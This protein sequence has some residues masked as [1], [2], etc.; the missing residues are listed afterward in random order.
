MPTLL[1]IQTS[2]RGDQS[3][4]RALGELFTH[5]WRDAHPGGVV[6]ER[7]L[8]A[9]PVP[10]MDVDWIAGVY[11]PSAV[12]RTPA[13]RKALAASD[14]LIDELQRADHVLVCTPMYNFTIPAA[15]KS[16]IDYVVRPNLT[17]ALAPGWP[18][19]LGDKSTRVLITARDTYPHGSDDDQ[20]TP[21]LRR[22][23][24]FMGVRDLRSLLVGGSSGVNRGEVRLDDH[25]ARFAEPVARMAREVGAGRE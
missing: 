2:P 24:A 17:F 1:R 10:T 19:L 18:G 25:I 5:H 21:V 13:M 22:A 8:A 14:E 7:D 12:E 11:A 6:V 3:I 23:F 4:S 20:V 16:W 15:L 9:T